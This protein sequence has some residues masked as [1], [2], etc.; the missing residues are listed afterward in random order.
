VTS[1]QQAVKL[2]SKQDQNGRSKSSD[3]AYELGAQLLAARFNL[4]AG[5]ETCLQAQQAI[6]VG[7]TLLDQINFVGSGDYLGSKSKSPN[8]PQSLAIAL[9]LDRYNN[10]DLC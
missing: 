6:L 1:C 7:H 5:A 10:G 4:G 9:T 3:G 8:R 2:L